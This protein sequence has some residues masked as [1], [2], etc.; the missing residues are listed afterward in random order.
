MKEILMLPHVHQYQGDYRKQL[1]HGEKKT[2]GFLT[3]DEKKSNKNFQSFA[4]LKADLK[5]PDTTDDDQSVSIDLEDQHNT[6][7]DE[8]V[9]I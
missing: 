4:K 2:L 9:F 5:K 8:T 1:D 3:T 6:H 7:P